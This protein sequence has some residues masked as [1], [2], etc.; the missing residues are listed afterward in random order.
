MPP[1]RRGTSTAPSTT[2]TTAPA[3]TTTT[4]PRP[5]S[6]DPAPTPPP[7]INT[8]T[9]YVAIAKSLLE[10]SNWLLAHRP[11]SGLIDEVAARG[12]SAYQSLAHD[13]PV[14][15]R[16]KRRMFEAT[17]APDQIDV[18][19]AT[20]DAVSIR[21]RQYLIRQTV[22]DASGQV[23]DTREKGKQPTTYLVLLSRQKDRWY[24]A[25]VEEEHPSPEVPL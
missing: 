25:S 8:G 7:L 5:Y 6:F 1:A 20:S 14:L 17:S 2:V 19:S 13:L 4:A 15:L 3:T 16:T 9:D 12:T 21:D 10:Y 11:D 24:L 22:V 18:V 23:R